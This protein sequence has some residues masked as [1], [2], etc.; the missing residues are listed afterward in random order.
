[1][2]TSR[3]V[4]VDKDYIQANAFW[5]TKC[6]IPAV[7]GWHPLM[8]SDARPPDKISAIS[9]DTSSAFL[10]SSIS[11]LTRCSHSRLEQ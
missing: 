9:M 8:I 3:Y 10:I 1:M 2:S 4:S 5:E 6:I 11:Q 7:S